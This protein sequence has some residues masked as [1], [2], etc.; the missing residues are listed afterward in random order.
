MFV[1]LSTVNISV[2]DKILW[3]G[4]GNV[5]ITNIW[6]SIRTGAPHVHLQDLVCHNLAIPKYALIL[7]LI[8]KGRL[9]TRD[10]M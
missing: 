1:L 6:Q 2:Q 5:K 8:V 3:Y 4:Q 10:Q 9:L 7:W